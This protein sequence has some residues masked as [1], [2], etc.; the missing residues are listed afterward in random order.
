MPVSLAIVVLYAWGVGCWLEEDFEHHRVVIRGKCR[1]S[2]WF[3]QWTPF[4]ENYVKDAGGSVVR[5]VRG[6]VWL[7]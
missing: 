1:N 7:G 5:K 3:G 2:F 6:L 4:R